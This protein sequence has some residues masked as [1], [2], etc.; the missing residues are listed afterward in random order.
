MNV[1]FWPIVPAHWLS[2]A[3]FPRWN[4]CCAHYNAAELNALRSSLARPSRAR[5]QLNVTLRTRPAGWETLEQVVDIWPDIAQFLLLVRGDTVFDSRLLHLMATQNAPAALVDS[6][7][8]SKFQPLVASA[9][10]MLG[11]KLCGAALLQRNWFST[12]SGPLDEA[13]NTGLEQ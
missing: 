7:V 4:A 9:P 11:V 2:F 3:A 8:P 12:Q 1:S 6:A 10:N 5:A 13:I